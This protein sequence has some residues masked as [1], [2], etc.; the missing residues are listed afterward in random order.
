M[1]KRAEAT[2]LENERVK[3]QTEERLARKRQESA[4]GEEPRRRQKSSQDADEESGAPT[5]TIVKSPI[6]RENPILK[7]LSWAQVG[8]VVGGVLLLVLVIYMSSGSSSKPET[9]PSQEE[10]SEIPVQNPEAIDYVEP[11]ILPPSSPGSPQEPP[12]FP[13]TPPEFPPGP[14]KAGARWA[15]L[16]LPEQC[17]KFPSA[18]HGVMPGLEHYSFST[19][20]AASIPVQKDEEAEE[21]E[22][23]EAPKTDSASELAAALAADDALEKKHHR[24][25]LLQRKAKKGRPMQRGEEIQVATPATGIVQRAPV[26]QQ[27]PAEESMEELHADSTELQAMNLLLNVTEV[28]GACQFVTS[29]CAES[30]AQ[31]LAAALREDAEAVSNPKVTAL[32]LKKVSENLAAMHQNSR[33]L[34]NAT[35]LPSLGRNG[36]LGNCAVAGENEYNPETGERYDS[37]TSRFAASIDRHDVLVHCAETLHY[38]TVTRLMPLQEGQ[39]KYI[40]IRI[41]AQSYVAAKASGKNI[42]ELLANDVELGDGVDAWRHAGEPTHAFLTLMLLLRSGLCNRIDVY[43]QPGVPARWFSNL[44]NGHI[45]TVPGNTPEDHALAASLQQ[46]RFVLRVAV[47]VFQGRLCFYK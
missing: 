12:P 41:D 22:E 30:A 20:A 47:H 18:P 17:F 31:A 10:I 29:E 40:T 32:E 45:V 27:A 42:H 2:R 6:A 3:R 9:E 15:R 44:G 16:Q 26:G 38:C 28:D 25:S 21:E 39:Q 5:P 13:E 24:R 19:P 23:E 7:N 33:T 4:S 35:E 14:P 46:E 1:S 36:A 34:L 37:F 8:G 11:E 43:G